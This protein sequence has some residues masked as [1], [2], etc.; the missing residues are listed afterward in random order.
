MDKKTNKKPVEIL[1]NQF[2]EEIDEN[3]PIP[4]S[5]D[6][7]TRIIVRRKKKSDGCTAFEGGEVADSGGSSDSSSGEDGGGY[8]VATNWD[9]RSPIPMGAGSTTRG[10][11][12]KTINKK[13][14]T[15]KTRKTS[16]K[17]R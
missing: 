12:I 14:L 13:S 1:E 4:L 17:K 9:I 8:D 7:K 2:I 16:R 3:L 6:A 10:R 15:K 11:K 5:F